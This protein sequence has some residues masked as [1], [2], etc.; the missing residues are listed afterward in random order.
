M[1][2]HLKVKGLIGL[3][4]ADVH[5]VVVHA[6]VDGARQ[7]GVVS[8]FRATTAIARVARPDPT[9][10]GAVTGG[11]ALREGVALVQVEARAEG[12]RPIHWHSAVDVVPMPTLPPWIM[13]EYPFSK[14]IVMCVS[15]AGS[16]SP[17][18]KYMA[19][20][21]GSVGCEAAFFHWMYGNRCA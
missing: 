7:H 1:H 18:P 13:S 21:L 3:P 10:A 15:L 9:T 6:M 12:E 2:T 20:L 4:Y 16:V 8:G 5:M 17:H 14:P 19:R 11:R